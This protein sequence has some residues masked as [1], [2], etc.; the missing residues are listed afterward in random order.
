MT[1]L[2]MGLIGLGGVAVVGV[3]A[4][5]KWQEHKHRKV[6][7][8]LLGARQADVL[9]DEKGSAGSS[10]FADVGSSGGDA[11][12]SPAT[13]PGRSSRAPQERVEPLLRQPDVAARA[14]A[15][16]DDGRPEG[17]GD[18]GAPAGERRARIAAAPLCL[19]SPAID[20]IAAIEL[21][22][23]VP[24]YLIRDAQRVV[25][26]RLGK[27]LHWIGFNEESH[28]WE[29]ISEDG[30]VAYQHIRVGLQLVDRKGP[31]RDADLSVFHVAIQDLASELMGAVELPLREPALQV[32]AQLDEFCAGVDIQIGLNVVSQ[33]QVFA[34]TKLR[35]LAESAGMVLDGDGRFVRL[36]EDGRLLYALLNQETQGFTGESIRSLTTHAIT[37]LL[38]VPRVANGDRVLGQMVEQARRFADSLHGQLVDDNRRP[39]SE[40]SIEPIRRQVVQYQLAMAHRQLPAGGPLAER[41]FS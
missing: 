18:D 9:L 7:E 12:D 20:Y 15:D 4:Y 32:A 5:N 33:G 37:F 6:A 38:D 10:V 13:A 2:Q 3:L 23:T 31:L 34:G 17:G 26:A 29:P 16:G 1:D 40:S 22:E 28:A 35:G 41:L 24:A 21:A 36:D 14:A 25:L 11:G 19:L 8:Q 30:D 27:P 39:V